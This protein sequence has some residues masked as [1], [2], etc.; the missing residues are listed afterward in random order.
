V[1]GVIGPETKPPLEKLVDGSGRGGKPVGAPKLPPATTG[2]LTKPPVGTKP[3]PAG[4]PNPPG[5]PTKP[6]VGTKPPPTGAPNPPAGT[7]PPEL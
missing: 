7:K 4:T 6:P 2:P 3:P 1:T 5:A